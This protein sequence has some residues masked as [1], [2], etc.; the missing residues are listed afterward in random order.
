[1]TIDIHCVTRWSKLGNRFAGVLLSDLLAASEPRDDAKFISFVARSDANHSTSLDLPTALG[2]QTLIALDYQGQPLPED[3]GGPI[4]N[5]VPGRYFYKS[6][7]WLERIEV[8]AEDRLGTWEADSGYHNQADPWLEQRYLA[9]SIS[10]REASRL[11]SLRDFSGQ[12]L[13][14]IDAS[15]RDLSRLNAIDS[16][17]RNANFRDAN[18]SDADF[19]NAYLSNAHFGNAT[20]CRATFL[21]AD[22]EG[23]DIGG[24]DL[25][26]V[27]FSGASLFG[28]SFVSET[29]S[30]GEPSGA[31]AVLN[32]ST[33]IRS[34]A[35]EQLTPRQA[36]YLIRSGVGVQ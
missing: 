29:E 8:L 34:S 19:R 33:T 31:G 3:H 16:L 36:D 6:V 13:L 11:I 4:R 14:G 7:K 24:A 1:M 22:C 2:Q 12:D 28:A 35:L 26:G 5:I 18:L 23:A 15:N 25:R 9:P 21:G 10:K 27:D 30:A 32:E 20:L 17:L